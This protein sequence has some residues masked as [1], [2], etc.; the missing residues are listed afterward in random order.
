MLVKGELAKPKVMMSKDSISGTVPSAMNIDGEDGRI[1]QIGLIT[2]TE[3]DY[4]FEHEAECKD[5]NKR[6][7]ES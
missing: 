3:C 2:G 1:H 5:H 6:E 7:Q 4:P